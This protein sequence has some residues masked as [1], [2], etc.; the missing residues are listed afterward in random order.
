MP[1]GYLAMDTSHKSPEWTTSPFTTNNAY[2]V[3]F[4]KVRGHNDSNDYVGNLL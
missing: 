4:T 1:P 2:I 3:G